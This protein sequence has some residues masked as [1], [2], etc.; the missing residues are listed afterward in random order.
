M[1]KISI[2]SGGVIIK[3]KKLLLTKRISTKSQFPDYWTFPAGRYEDSDELLKNTAIREVKEEV[4]LDFIPTSKLNFYESQNLDFLNVSHMYLGTWSG[5]VIF[6]KE[7]ISEVGWFTYVE[8]KNLDIAFAYAEVIE[9]LHDL[10][11][12]E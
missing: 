8:T 6:Q 5:E 12:I 11:L 3:D 4:N 10:K 7:E 2:G 9:D 1:K